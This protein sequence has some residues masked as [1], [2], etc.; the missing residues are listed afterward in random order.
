M[1]IIVFGNS[2][3]G[4]SRFA[5]QVSTEGKLAYLDLDT[6]AWMEETPPKRLPI[7]ESQSRI[8]SFITDHTDWIIEG[9]YA[10]LI[11]FASRWASDL[12]FLNPGIETCLHNCRSRP[13]EPHK[14]KSK[15]E[16][17]QNLKMLLDWCT[18]Y[19][20]RID[21][22]SYQEHRRVFESFTLSKTEIESNDEAQTYAA[23]LSNSLSHSPE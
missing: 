17:D 9:C 5:K 12:V 6:V 2:G 3:S 20:T 18:E 13:W 11:D 19:E 8:K 23:Q 22:Y 16:Q 14:Y 1:R 10:T 15:A 21:D 4:K 7:E